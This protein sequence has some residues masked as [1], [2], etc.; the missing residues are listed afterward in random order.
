M[1]RGKWVMGCMT[2]GL[3]CPTVLQAQGGSWADNV[4]SL[5]SVLDQLYRE[6]LPMCSQLI[7]VGR[8]IAG[9]AA[10][11]YI[12][13]RVWRHIANSEPIDFYPL[14]RPFV[15]GFAV[16]IFPSVIAMINGVM[17]PTVTA[18]NGMVNNSD[19]AVAALLKK[20][21]AAVKSSDIYQMYMGGVNLSTGEKHTDKWY[22]YTHPEDPNRENES[23][24]E[25]IGN[26]VLFA[27]DKAGYMFR[28]AIK[29]AIAEILQLLF[30]AVSLC[31]NTMRTFNLLVLAILGPLVFGL[32]V[33]DGFQH[34][35]K[36]WLARYINVFLWL[37]I[38]N[39]FG[40]IIGKIQENMLKIDIAQ[41]GQAGDTFFSRTDA[42]YLIFLIIGI[43]GYTT[44]PSIANYVMWVGGGDALNSKVTGA[45]AGAVAGAVS[46]GT[47]AAGAAAG[48][49]GSAIHAGVG[50]MGM[51]MMQ[52]GEAP[53]EV[54]GGYQSGGGSDGSSGWSKAGRAAGQ[55]GNY[56]RDKLSGN[57]K[58][59]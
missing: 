2:A 44:V 11:F 57:H 3:L 46:G 22:K 12:A 21:E 34:T 45:A 5:H 32:S 26:D 6:M 29:E 51:G 8:S 43:F 31:I 58:I 49:A 36:H 15:I 38:A 52:L 30:A 19:K 37:P 10:L 53:G 1:K 41:I 14:F 48:M 56:M 35:L 28:N 59:S 7:G 55:A 9:F 27:M 47:R 18:T 42:G 33:F 17:N 23:W 4:K 54:A 20:K 25:G 50:Q 40:A 16:I 39:L 13:A 24:Y